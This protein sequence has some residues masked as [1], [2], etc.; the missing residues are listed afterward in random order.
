MKHITR[1]SY[2]RA[3][4]E[5]V[6]LWALASTQYP[7]D[8]RHIQ[9]AVTIAVIEVVSTFALNARRALEVL[10]SG[11]KFMLSQPRW[12]WVP[13]TDGERVEHLWDALNRI[14][15]AQ[16]LRVG[17]EQLPQEQS[18]MQSGALIIPY[19][20]AATDRRKLAFIDP[21]ALAHAYLYG[22]VPL[23]AS[24]ASQNPLGAAH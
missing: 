24:A 2:E 23:L 15:H 20:R 3:S 9:D 21:F 4:D 12:H 6:R 10:P 22:A 17:F 19:V 8:N 11:H 18:V 13:T 7:K 16:E 1:H 5:A 14:I